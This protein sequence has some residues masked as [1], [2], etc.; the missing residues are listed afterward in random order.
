MHIAGQDTKPSSLVLAINRAIARLRADEDMLELL[1][2]HVALDPDA[3]EKVSPEDAR[4]N[5]TIADAVAA[6]LR[7]Q[8]RS[9]RPEDL[10][11]GVTS[12]DTTV[13]GAAGQLPAR[14]YTPAGP[15]PFPVVVYFHGGGW[16]LADKEVYDASARGL[17]RAARALVISVD[18]RL[19]PEHKFPAAW[20]DAF[21]AY[22]WAT[23]NA[24]RLGGDPR[25]VA[26]AGE[27]AG[28]NLALATA[29]AARDADVR[30][31]LHVLAIYPVAQTDLE[32]ESYIENAIALPLNRAM[33]QWF[34]EHTTRNGADLQDT[35]L[36][37]IDAP[38]E[39]LPPVTLISARIDPLRSDSAKLEA[40]LRRAD[41]AVERR[42]YAGV[43]H[44][45][46]GA[47]A[48]VAKA[49]AAQLWAG[50]R[51]RKAFDREITS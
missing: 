11:P 26:L 18:Y 24:Q 17:C 12:V 20:L 22:R 7:R 2:A 27:S 8:G 44:E 14:V 49:R 4:R 36:R 38:L 6:L 31:P 42:D 29:I 19:A 10:V 30:Q 43:T 50:E 37:L 33:M 35:R 40:A 21:A 16:V 1:N 13:K 15:G 23:E 9:S 28:G 32:T 47:A 34:F 46:F 41:V 45:F 5:P 39:R 51:L 3:I 25:Q 48:V